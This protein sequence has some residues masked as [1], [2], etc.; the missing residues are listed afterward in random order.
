M[1]EGLENRQMLAA[2]LIHNGGFENNAL[3]DSE[4]P[5]VDTSPWSLYDAIAGWTLDEG[6]KFEI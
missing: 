3:E 6:T 1:V 4:N 2:N 5:V